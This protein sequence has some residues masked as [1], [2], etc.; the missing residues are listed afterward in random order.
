ML[1]WTLTTA[2]MVVITGGGCVSETTHQK[3]LDQ[4]KDLQRASSE[5]AE[6]YETG[7]QQ[8][9]LEIQDLKKEQDRLTKALLTTQQTRAET[10]A[11]LQA[12]QHYLAKEEQARKKAEERLR[13]A[14][15]R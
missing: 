14:S 15:T 8:A 11:D 9:A 12:S 1:R 13:P 5:T 2:F 3:T 4:L 10:L 6:S 7:K